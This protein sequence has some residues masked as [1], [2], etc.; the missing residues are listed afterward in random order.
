MDLHRDVASSVE[1]ADRL[2]HEMMK[3]ENY[4]RGVRALVKKEIPEWDL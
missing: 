1:D 4:K 2:L 3:L